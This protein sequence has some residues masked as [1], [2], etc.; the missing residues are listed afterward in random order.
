MKTIRRFK[1]RYPGA[2]WSTCVISFLHDFTVVGT[3]L[4][5]AWILLAS[6]T[7]T[8][9]HPTY[10]VRHSEQIGD[11]ITR[12]EAWDIAPRNGGNCIVFI[13]DEKLAVGDTIKIVKK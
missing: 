2:D 1:N 5:F 7:V 12:Y 3:V 10:V 6:C 11:G 13:E 9:H 4:L 8:L